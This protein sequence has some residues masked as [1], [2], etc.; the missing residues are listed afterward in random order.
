M[1]GAVADIEAVMRD[2][3]DGLYR[4]DTAL[5]ARAFHPQALYATAAG[6]VPVIMDLP[7]YLPVVAR[8]DPPARSGDARRE[9]IVSIDVVGPSTALVKLECRFFQKDYVDFL[10][11]VRVDGRW[12][13][14]AKVFH[15][16]AVPD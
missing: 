6:D 16:T 14:I 4:C 10:T 15:F 8:R 1:S 3:L 11:L 2:Y 12:Q 9:R 13:I 7:S 5:L